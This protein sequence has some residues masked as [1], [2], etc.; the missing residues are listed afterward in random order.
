MEL[1]KA[2]NA[3]HAPSA[4]S[5]RNGAQLLELGKDRSPR[6][7]LHGLPRS[8]WSPAFGAGKSFYLNRTNRSGILSQWSPAFGAGKSWLRK[9][10]SLSPRC[11]RNGAQLLE[12]GKVDRRVDCF[13]AIQVAMEPSFWSW[14]KLTAMQKAYRQRASRNGAQLL[15]LGKVAKN[16]NRAVRDFMVA[17]EPSFWSWEKVMVPRCRGAAGICR[18]GA[19]LLEL[20]K[21]PA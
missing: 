20:G 3:S 11:S 2:S 10:G 8:Q 1:G 13:P 21:G 5:C 12:L 6:H 9:P 4:A 14:E 17:M 7:P 19:Q 18:N 15:E 16:F